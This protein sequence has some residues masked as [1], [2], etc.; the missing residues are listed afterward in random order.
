VAVTGARRGELC[1]LWWAD[2]N[3]DLGSVHIAHNY[4]V[5]SGQRIYK[6]T[7]TH[8][9]RRLA[10][11]PVTCDVLLAHR[12]R[13][14]ET[15][16]AVGV[17]LADSAYVFSNDPAGGTAWNPDWTSHQVA[18]VAAR[19]GVVLNIK[20]LRHCSRVDSPWSAACWREDCRT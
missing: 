8:Q 16:A 3:L 11:D 18:R 10:I 20:S 14:E 6:D 19:A 7:K 2:L 4:L 12:Q 17:G 13:V 1:G 9:E 15:L 5:R